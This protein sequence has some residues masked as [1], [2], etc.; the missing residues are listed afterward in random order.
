[1]QSFAT[2]V[3]QRKYF[4]GTILGKS[5]VV[6]WCG[7]IHVCRRAN[8]PEKKSNLFFRQS[9]VE[10]FDQVFDFQVISLDVCVAFCQILTQFG[11]NTALIHHPELHWNF[12]PFIAVGPARLPAYLRIDSGFLF[13]LFP[14]IAANA[15][16]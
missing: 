9:K 11:K 4:P 1:M 10:E 12:S 6:Y 7:M 13:R 5:H 3:K 2:F 16:T 14:V 15:G 8:A